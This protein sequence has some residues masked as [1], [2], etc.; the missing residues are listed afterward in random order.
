MN[1][2][3]QTVQDAQSA[4]NGLSTA[5]LGFGGACHIQRAQQLHDPAPPI[6]KH[7]EASLGRL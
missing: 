5:A 7:T 6:A 2:S 1:I 4:E 3:P